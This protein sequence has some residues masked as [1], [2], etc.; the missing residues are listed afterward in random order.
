MQQLIW[1][2]AWSKLLQLMQN[3]GTSFYFPAAVITDSQ[4][5]LGD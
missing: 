5:L 3:N 1:G 4:G 2:V